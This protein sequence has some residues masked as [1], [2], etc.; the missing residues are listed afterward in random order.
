MIY[1]YN[2][3][4]FQLLKNSANES[5][6]NTTIDGGFINKTSKWK[7]WAFKNQLKGHNI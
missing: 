5:K 3:N 6:T 2:K 7:R 4:Q 1:N